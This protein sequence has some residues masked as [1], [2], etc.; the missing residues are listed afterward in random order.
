VHDVE[1][2]FTLSVLDDLN[3]IDELPDLLNELYE[4]VYDR[5]AYRYLD[6]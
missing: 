1:E 2:R 3:D 5:P 6:E 4:M